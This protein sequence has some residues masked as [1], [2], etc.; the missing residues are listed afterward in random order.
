MSIA[1]ANESAE[2][3]LDLLIQLKL[4]DALPKPPEADQLV[5]EGLIRLLFRGFGIIGRVEEIYQQ[6]A[7]L[8]NAFRA[9]SEASAR[10]DRAKLRLPVIAAYYSGPPV[11]ISAPALA[12]DYDAAWFPDQNHRAIPSRHARQGSG[13][14]IH[15]LEKR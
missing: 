1:I 6:D 7:N 13:V 9:L 5:A 11:P 15:R 2:A 3:V 14:D 4:L 12:I 8:R 10:C